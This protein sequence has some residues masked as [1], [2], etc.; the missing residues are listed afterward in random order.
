MYYLLANK[1]L[2][3]FIVADCIL[4]ILEFGLCIIYKVG[5]RRCYGG[6][7]KAHEKDNKRIR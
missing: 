3:L 5:F 4:W 2:I 1:L 6:V 7:K